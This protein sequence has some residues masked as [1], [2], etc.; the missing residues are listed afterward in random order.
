MAISIEQLALLLKVQS[1]GGLW[2]SVHPRREER[3]Q[4][5]GV[6]F[7]WILH[8]RTCGLEVNPNTLTMS[9]G[10]KK[11]SPENVKPIWELHKRGQSGFRTGRQSST[12]PISFL[13]AITSGPAHIE[14]FFLIIKWYSVTTTHLIGQVAWRRAARPRWEAGCRR[15]DRCE[16]QAMPVWTCPLGI[17]LPLHS[18]TPM[19]AM[20]KTQRSEVKVAL[21]LSG[22]M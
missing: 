6:G 12:S 18:Q 8:W 7:F 14:S 9:L 13:S 2:D 3:R 11:L 17:P 10:T 15:R 20:K 21:D 19:V 1:K 16:M 4:Q 5:Q 22:W